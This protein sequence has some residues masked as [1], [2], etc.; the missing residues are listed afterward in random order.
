[1]IICAGFAKKKKKLQIAI[2]LG[3]H[4]LDTKNMKVFRDKDSER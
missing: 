3:K 2:Y 1:M 4:F